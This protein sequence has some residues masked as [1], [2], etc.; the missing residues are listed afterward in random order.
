MKGNANRWHWREPNCWQESATQ[1][2]VF[3][4]PCAWWKTMYNC[5]PKIQVNTEVN[6]RVL[7]QM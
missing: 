2:R 1:P 6:T 3:V 7:H 5:C 4:H